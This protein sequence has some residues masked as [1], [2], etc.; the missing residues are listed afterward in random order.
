VI[1]LARRIGEVP[2]GGL[3]AVVAD[4]P[5]AGSDVAAWCRLRDHQF[6]GERREPDGVPAY[7]VRRLT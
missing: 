1:E 6:V 4:D 3:L 7:L 5:A 2:L